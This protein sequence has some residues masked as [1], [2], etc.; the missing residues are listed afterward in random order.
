MI[1]LGLMAVLM[2]SCLLACKQEQPSTPAQPDSLH[3][4]QNQSTSCQNQVILE[5]FANQR[6]NVQVL[7]CG[8]VK[9]ILADDLK[10]SR[11]QKF[12][13]KL[14][15]GKQTVLI[16]HNID[17]APRLDALQKGDAVRFYGEYEYSDK[18]G[19]VHWTHHDP[20]GRHQGGYIEHQGKRYE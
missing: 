14:D 17:L 18:G 20:A 19:V 16:A 15:G 10:G 12:I 13:V 7:G 8:T 5:S 6:S 4:Q 11:H 2:S 9:A 1:K 3:K